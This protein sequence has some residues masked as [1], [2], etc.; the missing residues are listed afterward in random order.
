MFTELGCYAP[1]SEHLHLA[2]KRT[3]F[4]Y[5]IA[6]IVCTV[7]Y[8][9]Y[10]IYCI[11][12][13][14][15]LKQ[16]DQLTVCQP[17]VNLQ[18]TEHSRRDL[19]DERNARVHNN[20]SNGNRQR[21]RRIYQAFGFDINRHKL[22]NKSV[23]SIQTMVWEGQKQC[24]DTTLRSQ[25]AEQLRENGWLRCTVGVNHNH[26]KHMIARSA[27]PLQ[28]HKCFPSSTAQLHRWPR[29]TTFMCW[30]CMSTQYVVPPVI[31]LYCTFSL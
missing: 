28:R 20:A 18:R 2:R 1:M 30:Y 14:Y 24:H 8:C 13:W 17:F 29:T 21:N 3:V 6:S 11:F 16:D 10:C 22:S 27:I 5:V 4:L 19:Q 9:I 31:R 23:P 7:L 12:T 15:G 26:L 25:N